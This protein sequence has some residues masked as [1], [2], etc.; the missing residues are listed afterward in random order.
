MDVNTL[1]KKVTVHVGIN[2]VMN[3]HIIRTL[4]IS[5]LTRAIR[6]KFPNASVCFSS[7]I[8][9]SY[10]QQRFTAEE[11]NNLLRSYCERNNIVFI[12]N[13]LFCSTR[14]GAPKKSM[15]G[16]DQIHLSKFGSSMLAK[17]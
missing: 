3:G 8:P 6:L 2:D 12:D 9:P 4:A 7:I 10:G 1:V 14:S 13:S 15:Y 5:D 11:S 17:I 16:G